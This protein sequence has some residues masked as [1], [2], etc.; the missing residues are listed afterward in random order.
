MG[1]Y[2]GHGRLGYGLG[3]DDLALP[4]GDYPVGDLED[5]SEAMTDQDHGEEAAP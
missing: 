1:D 3:G 4:Q 5:I 2:P